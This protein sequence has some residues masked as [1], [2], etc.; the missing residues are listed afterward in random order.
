MRQKLLDAGIRPAFCFECGYNL[1]G[2]EGSECPACDAPLLRQAD[3]SP[4]TS[5]DTSETGHTNVGPALD[6]N[7]PLCY[8]SLRVIE[9][10]HTMSMIVAGFVKNGVVVPNAPNL[11]P[12]GAFVEVHVI[13]GPIEVPPE[14][15]EEFDAWDLR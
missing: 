7:W 12:E 9:E 1:E 6:G 4:K 15:Q 11:L 10:G 14:L 2:Y 3:A 5:L 13:H 8:N